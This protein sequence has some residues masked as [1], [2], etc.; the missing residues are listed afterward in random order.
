VAK[1]NLKVKNKKV[2]RLANGEWLWRKK[3]IQKLKS[4]SKINIKNQIKQHPN[5]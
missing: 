3:K 2:G 1:Q 4:K 5:Y